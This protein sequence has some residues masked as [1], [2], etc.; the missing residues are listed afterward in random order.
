MLLY[1][2]IYFS[3]TLQFGYSKTIDSKIWYIITVYNSLSFPF[4]LYF[5][6]FDGELGMCFF[7]P[8]VYYL[9][10]LFNWGVDS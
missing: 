7:L 10:L 8:Y 4:L 5:W 1:Y 3:I 6:H 9:L 2:S